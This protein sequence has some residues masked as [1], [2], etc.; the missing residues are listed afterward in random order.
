MSD[1]K[2]QEYQIL[3]HFKR[4]IEYQTTYDVENIWT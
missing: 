4:N 3:K 1:N 2:S